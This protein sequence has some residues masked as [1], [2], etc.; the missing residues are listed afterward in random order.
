G[1][2]DNNGNALRMDHHI[3]LDDAVSNFVASIDRYDYDSL[4]RLKSV[5]ELSYTKGP[6]GNDV[7]QGIFRQ[8]FLYDRW[9]NRT[10]D[11]ANTVGAV[12]N[13]G[14]TVV[15]EENR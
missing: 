13:K 8:S 5:T 12:R 6:S 10:I 9:G 3:P 11:Q 1:G 2:T 15:M 14:N 7:Y 4:N